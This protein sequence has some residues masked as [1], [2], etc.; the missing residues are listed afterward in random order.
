[1]YS[2]NKKTILIKQ[3]YIQDGKNDIVSNMEQVITKFAK[4]GSE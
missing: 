1:M 4:S 2:V 3:L